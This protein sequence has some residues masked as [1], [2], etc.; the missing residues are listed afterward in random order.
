MRVYPLV[1]IDEQQGHNCIQ[2][3]S[4][5]VSGKA[6]YIA[7]KSKKWAHVSQSERVLGDL[8]SVVGRH[9][10]DTKITNFGRGIY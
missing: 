6:T 7:I 3:A 2:A 5:V 1:R 4:R 9:Y 8:S 10:I